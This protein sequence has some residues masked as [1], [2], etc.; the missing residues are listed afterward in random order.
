MLMIINRIQIKVIYLYLLGFKKATLN[1]INM[2]QYLALLFSLI[3]LASCSSSSDDNNSDF[4]DVVEAKGYYFEG[5]FS[6]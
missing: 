6:V 3:L 1:L 2:K 4:N 5:E